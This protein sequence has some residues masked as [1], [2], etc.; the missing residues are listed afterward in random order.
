MIV[1][2]QKQSVKVRTIPTYLVYEEINGEAIPYKGYE[3]VLAGNKKPEEIMG[4]SSLQAVLVY[5]IG[6]YIGNNINR[7]KYF[8]GSNES[9]LHLGAGNN[10]ANDIAVFERDNTKLDNKYFRKAPKVVIEVDSKADLRETSY[11]TEME[12]YVGKSQKMLDFGVEKIVWIFTD[13]KKVLVSQEG[14][15]W[16]LLDFDRDVLLLDDCVLN[17]AKLLAE[18]EIEF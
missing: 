12:Y 1:L 15:D 11:D 17:V 6:L 10:L 16:R 14:Q 3:E 7:K 2:E 13:G 5:L 8:V 18:E 4:S 9:G